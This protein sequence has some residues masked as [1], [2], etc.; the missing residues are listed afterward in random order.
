M[1]DTLNPI[2][3]HTHTHIFVYI[4]AHTHTLAHNETVRYES[5]LLTKVTQIVCSKIA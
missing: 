5:K 3:L 1:C 2:P 4:Y